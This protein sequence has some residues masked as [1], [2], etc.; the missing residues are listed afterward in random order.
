MRNFQ[1]LLLLSIFLLT[2]SSSLSQTSPL[3]SAAWLKQHIN[4]PDLVLI[5]VAFSRRDYTSGHIPGARFAWWSHLVP[6]TPDYSSELP[7]QMEL[8]TLLEGLGVSNMSK[9]VV[10][11]SRSSVTSATRSLWTL[12]YYG[13]A[14]RAFMLDGGLEAWKTAGGEMSTRSTP[15]VRGDLTL[16]PDPNVIADADFIRNALGKKGITVIDARSKNFYDGASTGN[17]RQ[18]HI[19]GA[20]S[21]P[22]SSFVDSLNV[23]KPVDSLKAM[24]RSAGVKDG[25]V[26]VTY[27]H[28][29]QQA[30]VALQAARLSGYAARL[31]DGS[32]DDWSY[33]DEQYPMEE[34][35]EKKQ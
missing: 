10:Y 22:F 25:D 6:S 14:D 16:R 28:V 21:L 31:Y 19:K 4:D 13:L 26:V 30:T 20:V 34:S 24:F 12:Q 3:V 17:P 15:V 9:I 27:C 1:L 33:R 32:M 8:D 11:F 2:F 23:F 5:H 35:A 29:G 18:G 7:S